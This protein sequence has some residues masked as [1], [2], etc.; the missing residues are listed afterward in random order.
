MEDLNLFFDLSLDMLC[1]AGFDGY[2]KQLNPIWEETL[3]YTQ[4]ELL[5][6]PYLE[7]I[8]PDDRASTVEE[9][10]NLSNNGRTIGFENRYRCKDGSYRWFR[11]NATAYLGKQRIY[12]VARDVTQTKQAESELRQ[13]HKTLSRLKTALDQAAVVAITDSHGTIVEVNDHFCHLSQ[14]SREELIGQ[15]HRIVNSGYHSQ[16][17]FRQMWATITQGEI[18]K[19]EIR[20]QAKDGSHY[21]V[22]T[23]IVPFMDEEGQPFQYLAIR[24]DITA[25]KQLEADLSFKQ[26][27]LND[28]I[29]NAPIGMHGVDSEGQILW[30]N[31]YEMEL[32]GY[33]PE[34]YIGQ[35]ISKFYHDLDSN[36]EI[37]ELLQD[38]QKIH[39]G[40][41]QLKC[42]D[43]SVRDVLIFSNIHWH[44]GNFV[45][46]R[47]FTLDITQ[48]KQAEQAL[49]ESEE[50]FRLLAEN[51][52][53]VFWMTRIN[54]MDVTQQQIL[55]VSPA[56]EDIW[57]RDRELL[58]HESMKWVEAIHPEDRDRITRLFLEEVLQGEFDHEYRIVRPDGSVRWIRDRGSPVAANGSDQCLITG[59]AEDITRRKQADQRLRDSEER[60]RLALV[61]AN[62]GLWDLNIQT[63][64]TIV[65]SEYVT[66]LG[67]DPTDFQESM[68]KWLDRLHPD[69]RERVANVYQ[70][71]V[72]GE[73]SRYRVDFRQR[74]QSGDWKWILSM[75]KI[76]DWDE[77]GQPL[78][79]LGIHM[80]ISDRKATEAALQQANA[81]LESRV[82]ERTLEL[83]QAK[84]AA[85]FANRSKSD[86]LANMSHE[87]RTP[88]NGVLGYAQ[89]LKSDPTISPK[90][91]E[92]LNIIEQCGSQLLT[93][94]ND[95]LNLAKIEAGKLELTP[96]VFH[97][98]YFLDTVVE[99]CHLRTQQKDLEF[100]Y[101]TSPSLP[102]MVQTDEKHLRQVLL[103][104]ISNATKF[105]DVGSITFN[106]EVISQ[107][108]EYDRIRFQVIDT[109]IGI[110]P[111]QLEHIFLPFV[112]VC[113]TSH[114]CEGTGLGLS[115]TQRILQ[116][117]GSTLKVESTVNQG[118]SFWFELDL[119]IVREQIETTPMPTQEIVGYR[120]D[121]KTLLLVDDR[122]ENRAVLHNLLAPLGFDILEAADGQQGIA[123]AV[124]SRPD[125]IFVDLMMPEMDGLE[126]TR[127]IRQ[128]SGLKTI[129]IIACSAKTFSGD[130]QDSLEAGC[131]DFLA[132]PV[133]RQALLDQL[134]QHLGLDWIYRPIAANESAMT[135]VASQAQESQLITPPVEILQNLYDLARKGNLNGVAALATQL[136]QMDTQYVPFANR[137]VQMAK[138]FQDQDLLQLINQYRRTRTNTMSPKKTS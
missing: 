29:E 32:L 49:K 60:L 41:A 3:G 34:E 10:Q 85:E 36:S 6:T 57:G 72:Q 66:M 68:E 18:W 117:M 25:Q 54:P 69:D 4:A 115:I 52:H 124:Q 1:I 62:Q 11:W 132:K 2:F 102:T 104:L 89:I 47:C 137:V 55:Y 116:L 93:L 119:P 50:K 7:L 65:S 17:F 130:R 92:K 63:G 37:L 103:N 8:H 77:A 88:L 105:T 23:T 76:V 56:Y 71:Y 126:M 111:E 94:I 26:A 67:Y 74:T 61:A 13:A 24:F 86:F 53:E 106:A 33:Q 99:I 100:V 59:I 127:R 135:S 21:W 113:S 40:E 90:Q 44:G 101:R 35:H 45:N 91:K 39:N 87:L 109:G 16:H 73:I 131:N 81:N 134:Q 75:G 112:Q 30:A 43:G 123:L 133:Q 51:L 28:F 129:K 128:I 80:D 118:S 31:P 64:E 15:T 107:T 125:L 46:T 70:T 108:R 78:R 84:E 83:T 14:Y 97:L 120:G 79:M 27:Q 121:P 96:K 58:Y 110:A 114:Q 38:Q 138:A 95:I 98:P 136:E 82:Q 22:N 20:N 5:T 12:C 48:R 122:W 9:V 19:G 42:K